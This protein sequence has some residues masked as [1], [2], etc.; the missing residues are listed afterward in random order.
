MAQPLYWQD[1]YLRSFEAKVEGVKDGK[2]VVLDRTAFYP[3]SGGQPHD[4][5]TMASGGQQYNVVFAGKFSGKIS[6][7]VDRQGL[8]EGDTVQCEIDWDRRHMLMRMHTAAHIIIQVLH[9]EAGALG[10]G[11]QLD[12]DKSRIDFSLDDYN[13]EMLERAVSRANEVV[14]E[15]LPVR[16]EF[17]SREE[18]EKIPGLSKLAMGLPD[19]MREVRVV[20]IGDFDVQA[21]GGTHVKS[22]KEIGKIVFLDTKNKGKGRKRLYYTLE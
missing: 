9:E 16:A 11:N 18:A 22:T 20:S 7:E 6:H 17:M 10:T 1:S 21:D 8:Q 13:P 12:T 14:Q 15:D 3:V 19:G 5:G 4:T 2:Y